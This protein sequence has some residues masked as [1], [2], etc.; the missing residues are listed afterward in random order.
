MNKPDET[1]SNSRP[2]FRLKE[3][4]VWLWH[5]HFWLTFFLILVVIVLFLIFAH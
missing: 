5:P 1:P 2:A 3:R 4:F